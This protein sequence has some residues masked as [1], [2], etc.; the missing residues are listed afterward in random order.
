V[1]PLLLAAAYYLGAQVGFAL[2]SPTAPQSVLWLPNSILLAALLRVPRREWPKYL[3]AAFPAHM[4]VA[5]GA[6]A[7]P[8]TMTLLYGTNCADAALGAWLVRRMS[9]AEPFRFNTLRATLIFLAFGATL[10]TMLLSFADA[11]ISLAT[12]WADSFRDPLVTRIRSNVLTHMIVVPALIDLAGVDWGRVRRSRVIEAVALYLLLIVTCAAAFAS[13]SG[14]RGYPAVLYVPLPLLLWAAFRFGPGGTGWSFLLVAVSA[15]WNALQGRGPFT[16]RSPVEDVVALQLFLLAS[17]TPLLLLSAVVRE[18]NRATQAVRRNE[19]ALRRS[20]ARVR[21]LAGK[22]I[23]AQENE[24]ARIARDLHDDFNQQLAALSISISALRQRL[25]AADPESIEMLQ[26]LQDRMVDLTD[27]VRY[28]S[29]GLHPS[30]LDHVGLAAALRQHCV[31]FAG[32]HG[33]QVNVSVPDDLGAVPRDAAVSVYRIVQE[34]LRNVATHAGVREAS[35]SLTRSRD[36]IDATIGDRGSGFDPA[37]AAH[38]GL[39]LLSMEER[40]R[41]V[42]GTL[43]VNSAPGSGTT[44]ALRL[45]LAP[46]APLKEVGA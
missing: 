27:R 5:L 35:V 14:S 32:E 4:L 19:A 17:A 16:S 11:G 37:A 28:F 33:I 18:R 24:R 31:Q 38:G 39:G 3:L 40:A 13:S 41:L 43:T 29:H 22:L 8:L 42:G 30:T 45:P 1:G 34:A 2:Q 15:S 26:R 6:G 25:R 7:P 23:A 44:V 36:G 10:P 20:Y 21:E 12:A 46:A 9:Q